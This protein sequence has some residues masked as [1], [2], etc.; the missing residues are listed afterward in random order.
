MHHRAHPLRLVQKAIWSLSAAIYLAIVV[1]APLPFG[2]T[3]PVPIALCC[4]LLALSLATA[5]LPP[6]TKGR[7]AVMVAIMIP[8]AAY[9]AVALIQI[10]PGAANSARPA[11][12]WA[13]A[14]AAGYPLPPLISWTALTPW[15]AMGGALLL[16]LS[17]LRAMVLSMNSRLGTRLLQVIAISGVLYALF[18]IAAHAFTPTMLLWRPKTAYLDAV[19]GPFVNRNTAATYWGSCAV[20]CCLFAL[21]A[22]DRVQ[23]A[24][25][26]RRSLIASLMGCAICLVAVA[27]TGSRAGAALTFTAL[28]ASIGFWYQDRGWARHSRGKFALIALGFLLAVQ[29]IGAPI[30]ERVR[31][32]G[33]GDQRRADV[34]VATLQMIADHP[35]LGIGLGNFESVF[36][37]YRPDS[38]GSTSVWDRAHSTPLEIAAEVGLPVTI[39]ALSGC[40]ALG[41][42]L[43][44]GCLRRRRDRIMPIAGFCVGLLGIGHSTIDFSLQIAGYGVV[45]AAIVG[46]GLAQSFTDR[47][48]RMD[49][50]PPGR[51]V[52]TEVGV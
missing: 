50:G 14:G 9:L 28:L 3:A 13:E 46:C 52:S 48:V 21:E 43:L 47:T 29:V 18:G 12:I 16:V 19:T 41:Y 27:M 45:F 17:L 10:S 36:P 4:L 22:S 34:Y 24:T 11:A 37:R 42:A 2:L 15:H 6:V 49:D 5:Q 1:L 31:Q 8:A 7:F 44:T 40:F 33:L 51:D 35:W 25:Q 30:I 26:R 20:L 38:I 39:L 32:Y 23:R